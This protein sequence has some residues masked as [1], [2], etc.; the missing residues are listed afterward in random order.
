M[1]R[2]GRLRGRAYP[3]AM[4][5][6]LR[7]SI[8]VIGDEILGGFVTDTNSGWLAGRLWKH[9]VPLDRIVTVPDDVSAIGEALRGELDRDRPRLVLTS[10]GI[11][12][13]PDD[14]T[15]EAVAAG[16]G[17]RVEIEPEIDS[18]ITRLL[19]RTVAEGAPVTGAHARSIRK[20]A[21]VP[22]GA[23]LLSGAWSIAPG[24]ALDV[25]GGVDSPGGATIV[26]LPGIPSEL[27]RIVAGAVEPELLAGRGAPRHVRE[28]AHGYPESALN[29][30][31]DRLVGE[32]PDVHVG[33][34]PG[35][36]CVIRLAGARERVDVAAGEVAAYLAELDAAPGAANLRRS[37][38]SRWD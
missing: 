7:S 32:F 29:P 4:L 38:Q 8:V 1:R 19:E 12:T 23:Y 31:L 10:G 11:G 17:I 21:L 27:K 25:D 2:G 13:T 15:Y 3:V 26:I 37:W 34:Y 20:M 18:R 33:S 16:L 5:V 24:V 36:E 30:V 22:E 9:G 14:R 6:P 35:R 28:L